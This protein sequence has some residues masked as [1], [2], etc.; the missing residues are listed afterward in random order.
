MLLSTTATGRWLLLLALT[1]LQLLPAEASGEPCAGKVRVA[2]DV[3]HSKALPGARSA[4]GKWEHDFNKRFAEELVASSESW[5]DMALFMLTGDKL[6]LWGRPDQAAQKGADLFLSIHHDSV[7]K[8]YIRHW[9]HEGR[10]REYSDAFKGYSLFVWEEG[11]HSQESIAA[12]KLMG[13][14]LRQ[15][16]FSPTLHHAE[17]VAGENRTLLDRELGIYF[18]PFAVLRH[19]KIPAVLFEVGVIINREEETKLE[20]GRVRAKIQLQ[21]LN[22]LR[23]FCTDRVA[24]QKQTVPR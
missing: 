24:R 14:N 6:S 7:L 16:G 19:A 5:P 10:W 11:A 23:A 21:L 8:K 15:A 13:S 3:G 20:D 1:G 17:P 22:A 18:A 9:W 4:T 2:I 12:A